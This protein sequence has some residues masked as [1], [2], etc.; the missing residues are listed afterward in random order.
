MRHA[1]VFHRSEKIGGPGMIV[2]I[3]ESAFGKRKYERGRL[4]A[5]KWVFGGIERGTGK[6][7]MVQV[8]SGNAETLLPLIQEWIGPG[9]HMHDGWG[10]YND[11]HLLPEHY[12]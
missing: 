2:E 4:T 10:A 12:P 3:D 5:V 1:D 11:I 8:E 7:F 9:T 6:C